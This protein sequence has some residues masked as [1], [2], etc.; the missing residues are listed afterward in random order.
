MRKTK[1]GRPSKDNSI[2]SLVGKPKCRFDPNGVVSFNFSN[3]S[4]DFSFDHKDFSYDHYS[5]FCQS[6]IDISGKNWNESY[7]AGKHSRIGIEH[8]ELNRFKKNND[9]NRLIDENEEKLTI[10]RY[11]GNLPMAG[12]RK[13]DIFYV[14]FLE[15]KYDDLYIH[16]GKK[17]QNWK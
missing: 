2:G 11:H 15:S 14:I 3:L 16:D 6:L 8:L 12:L 10:F 17:A 7:K 1:T 5:S 13:E 4:K 9:I